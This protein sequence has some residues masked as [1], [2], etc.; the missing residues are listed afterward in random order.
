VIIAGGLL[1]VWGAAVLGLSGTMHESW[2]DM[3][4]RIG[5]AG[6]QD[7]VP[8]TRWFASEQGLRGMR[9]GGAVALVAGLALIAAGGLQLLER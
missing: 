6:I 3:N 5:A 2:R 4:R 8:F 7:R 1:V 9:W